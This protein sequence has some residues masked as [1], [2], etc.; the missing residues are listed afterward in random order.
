MIQI[1]TMPAQL[2]PAQPQQVQQPVYEITEQ[3]KQRV[4]RIGDA[5]KAYNGELNKPLRKMD[6]QPDDNVMSNRCAQIADQGAAFLFG[7]EVE[8]SVEESASPEAQKLL[9]LTWGRK[10]ARIPLLQKLAMNGAMAGTAFLRIVPEPNG[11]YRL[12]VVDPATVYVQTAPQDCETVLLYCIQYCTHQK[13]DGKVQPVY[14]REEIARVDPDGDGDDGDPFADVDANWSIGHWSRVGERGPWTSA[15][16]PIVWPYS[17]PPLFSCQNLPRPNDFWGLPD[18]TP[19]IIGMNQSLN[20][21][22]SCVN[23]VLKLYG[24]PIIYATGTGQQVIDIRPGKILGLPLSESKVVAVPITSDV[25]SALA[26]ADNLRSDI[27]EQSAVPGIATARI[28][29]LPRGNL[30]GIAIELLFM[31]I[32]KKT[33][34]K[35]CLYG[36]L[37]INTSK[38]LFVLNGMGQD[39]DV[40]LAWQSAVPRDG[41]QEAQAAVLL[42]QIGVSSATLQREMGYD[43]DEELALSQAEDTQKAAQATPQAPLQGNGEQA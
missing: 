34:K 25:A 4:H 28:S 35:Q 3:D 38:A 10:E 31:P 42:K 17:F 7:K 14:Y 23:R 11:T 8:I 37:L 15:G 13:I 29:S 21:V 33:D 24:S 22:Q 2:A 9:D 36:D 32:V 12:V 41:V 5:W 1:P 30:S 26:F 6:D 16:A 20:L 39:L 40:T 43:P 27:D 18:I 19:D